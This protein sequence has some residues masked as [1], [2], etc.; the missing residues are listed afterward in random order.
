[1]GCDSRGVLLHSLFICFNPRTRMGCDTSAKNGVKGDKVSIHA[2]AW[3]AT[4]ISDYTRRT[5][6]FQSTH[7]HGVRLPLLN[8]PIIL[9]CFNPRTRMGCDLVLCAYASA[10]EVSI[11]APAW[12]ATCAVNPQPYFRFC[13]NPRTRMGCDGIIFNLWVIFYQVSIHAPAWGAT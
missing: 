3:G 8:I 4:V 5:F 13:F 10:L 12:G 2:P 7:P 1:M 9:L 11:H 6:K